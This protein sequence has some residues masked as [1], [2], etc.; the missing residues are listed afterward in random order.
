[1]NLLR[2]LLDAHRS[3]RC[4]P[5]SG[6]PMHV[7]GYRAV[8]QK[9]PIEMERLASAGVS[10]EIMDIA[11]ADFLLQIFARQGDPTD[12][13][14]VAEHTVADNYGYMEIFYPNAKFIHVIRDGRAVANSFVHSKFF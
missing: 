13:L 14:C 6:Y 8:I 7:V 12:L 9:S 5:E 3:V 10:T 1:M 11:F 2:I 4:A